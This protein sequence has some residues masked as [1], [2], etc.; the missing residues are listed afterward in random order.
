MELHATLYHNLVNDDF[1]D[2]LSDA[3]KFG[4]LGFLL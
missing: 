2:M 4:I 1:V 3:K